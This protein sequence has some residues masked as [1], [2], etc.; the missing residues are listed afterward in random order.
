MRELSLAIFFSQ[1][2]LFFR[3]CA[4]SHALQL[5]TFNKGFTRATSAACTGGRGLA[6]VAVVVAS[7]TNLG[8]S[9]AKGEVPRSSDLA[10]CGFWKIEH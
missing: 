4:A 1:S 8:P 5:D 7:L 10:A 9:L 3:G 6:T 2:P